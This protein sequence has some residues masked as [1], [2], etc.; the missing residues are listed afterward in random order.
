MNTEVY[1]HPAAIVDP[2]VQVGA[3]SRIWAF[4]HLLSG[5]IVGEDCN[6]CDHTFIEGGVRLGDRVT[7][8]CGVYLWKGIIAESDVFIGPAA[9][10]TNDPRPR[11]QR[12]LHAHPETLLQVGCSI[13]AGAII[14]PG[15]VI[16]RYSM[17][18]AGAVVTRNV[19]DHGLVYGNPAELR[20]WICA[21]GANLSGE[22]G[23]VTK[24]EC[25]RSLL[26]PSTPN[27]EKSNCQDGVV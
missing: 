24:C 6:I 26:L 4:A 20:G 12:H 13:G 8:K 22:S 18:G 16:G 1:I 9:V 7:V 5:A 17:V 19:P 11:S 2:D 25:G 21:C 23:K 10:F 3:R 15:L 14:L 27:K